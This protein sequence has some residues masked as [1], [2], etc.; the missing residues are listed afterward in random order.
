MKEDQLFRVLLV[1]LFAI[2]MLG[3][4]PRSPTGDISGASVSSLAASDS[5]GAAIAPASG[6]EVIFV[7]VLI[8]IGVA[9]LLFF[10]LKKSQKQSFNWDGFVRYLE[11]HPLPKPKIYRNLY[12]NHAYCGE[13]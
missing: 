3:L 2:L 11:R 10:F 6:V 8:I 5:T 12:S 7:I 9:G 1:S 4:I 13:C